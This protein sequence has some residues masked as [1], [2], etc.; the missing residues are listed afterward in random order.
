MPTDRAFVWR[1][2]FPALTPRRRAGS[3]LT[4]PITIAP[5]ARV[6]TVA[7]LARPPAD[8]SHRVCDQLPFK[9]GVPTISHGC[10][11]AGIVPRLVSAFPRPRIPSVI[12]CRRAL[13]ARRRRHGI[14]PTAG[15]AIPA[16]KGL[17]PELQT[18]WPSPTETYNTVLSLS[19]HACSPRPALRQAQGEVMMAAARRCHREAEHS[20]IG[21]VSPRARRRQARRR[22]SFR[23]PGSPRARARPWRA[24]RSARPRR[25]TSRRCRPHRA[26]ARRSRC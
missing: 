17:D 13:K 1:L 26:P 6:R 5:G 2:G 16:A 25:R 24:A 3:C 21:R 18:S 23:A 10:G 8:R 11:W 22:K 4:D 12:P 7:H 19:K 14:Q 9:T 15:R 20:P